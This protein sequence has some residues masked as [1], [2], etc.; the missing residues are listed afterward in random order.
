MDARGAFERREE[1]LFVD[2]RE[3][4][5]RDA[6]RIEGS[7]HIPLGQLMTRHSEIEADGPVV[8][9]C[10]TGARSEDAAQ[11]LRAMGLAEVHNLDGG[12]VAWTSAGLPFEGSVV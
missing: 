4:W 12:I 3:Q 7:L 10:R 1:F 5:E 6:G 11:F 2:V 9:V 8:V